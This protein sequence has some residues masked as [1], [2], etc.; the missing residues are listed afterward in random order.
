MVSTRRQ[1]A[2]E[3]GESVAYPAAR[4]VTDF[5]R[6]ITDVDRLMVDI[7]SAAEQDGTSGK[8]NGRPRKS[9]LNDTI[10]TLRD[11]ARVFVKSLR[12][13]GVLHDRVPI[14]YLELDGKARILR[15]NEECA[16][17]LNGAS[18]P[19]VGR[20]LFDF[21]ADSDIKRL[22]ERFAISRHTDKPCAV[23]VTIVHK[24]KRIPVEFRIRRQFVGSEIGYLAVIEGDHSSDGSNSVG[25]DGAPSLHE[26]VVSL[27][28]AYTLRSVAEIVGNYC[29]TAFGS[30]AGM[31]FIERDG[32]L[33]LLSKWR[34]R[35]ISKKYLAEETIKKGPAITAFRTGEPMFWSRRRKS[36]ST[37]SR[38][39]RDPFPQSRG[40]SVAFLPICGLEQRPLGVLTIVLPTQ[41]EVSP[42]V[43]DELLRLGQIVSG[44]IVRA[45]AYDEALDARARAEHAYQRKEEF[46]SVLSH[47][48][49]NPMMPI[50]GWAVALGSG[51]LPADRQ[52]Q[53]I[54]GIVRNVRALNYLIDDLFDAAR[55]SSGKLRLE[56]GEMRIQEIAREALTA[57]QHVAEDKKLRISTDISEAVPPFFADSRRVRQV[58]MNLL[59]NAVKFTSGGGSIALKIVRR[60]TVVQCT[61]S[62]TGKG[63][64]A[65]FLPFVFDPFRQENRLTK[66]KN[67]GL[68]LGLAIVREIVTLHGGTIKALSAGADQGSTFILRLPIS[69]RR[70][71]SL[72]E[73]HTQNP[74]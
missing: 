46:F 7:R 14:P 52:N 3:G 65:K 15:T 60:G 23:H 58:L 53:A 4:F 37:I 54:E 34:S 11:H 2:Q 13:Y 72:A 8:T 27:S 74:K 56:L 21:V 42:E 49:K 59:T 1:S 39:L 41:D 20:S 33:Q 63:I 18:T 45:R 25:K 51:T 62:D 10:S 67:S 68:G 48:L 30:P 12:Y 16:E 61:V 57:I 22:R 31:I 71:V 66:S 9:T 32:D 35:H 28:R 55:I 50:L 47:E 40:R 73:I 19:L 44:C 5:A 70:P 36:G 43:R 26:L 64:E 38:Y 24:G 17:M 29:R 6:L 69:R